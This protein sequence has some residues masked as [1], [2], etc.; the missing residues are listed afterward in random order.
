MAESHSN[1]CQDGTQLGRRLRD[2]PYSVAFE[3]DP[4][5][6]RAEVLVSTVP[7]LRG[8]RA[9]EIGSKQDQNLGSLPGIGN[10]NENA[11]RERYIREHEP[12][13][14]DRGSFIDF[15]EYAEFERI[16]YGK[17]MD[18]LDSSE[19]KARII[20]I[21]PSDDLTDEIVCQLSTHELR[22][23][24]CEPYYALSYS[25]KQENSEKDITVNGHNMR[26]GLNL[27][28]AMQE[29]RRRGGEYLSLWADGICIK[30]KG[31]DHTPERNF[32]VKRCGAFTGRP[33]TR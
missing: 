15:E 28:L 23:S 30:Q 26:I 6:F 3:R 20:H 11:K 31:I 19:L 33:P 8:S 16:Y 9:Y 24:D 2:L 4:A 1:W 18:V 14:F 29:C 22:S 32:L 7:I 13:A 10:D 17:R 25:W 12:T 21:Q 5:E 27:C